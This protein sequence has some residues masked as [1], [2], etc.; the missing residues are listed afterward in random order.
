MERQNRKIN[1]DI[2]KRGINRKG[3]IYKRAFTMREFW[4][5]KT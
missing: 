4:I 1:I 5:L 3:G 2:V